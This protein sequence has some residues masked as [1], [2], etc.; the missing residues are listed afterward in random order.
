MQIL[1]VIG[2]ATDEFIF[3][4]SW[5]CGKACPID[6]LPE[7]DVL[8]DYLIFVPVPKYPRSTEIFKENTTN[9]DDKNKVKMMG[10]DKVWW[11]FIPGDKQQKELPSTCKLLLDNLDHDHFWY[12]TRKASQ[13]NHKN[14]RRHPKLPSHI[15]GPLTTAD[16]FTV[17][18]KERK[19]DYQLMVPHSFDYPGMT[20]Y[21]SIFEDVLGIPHPGPTGAANVVLQNKVLTR[22]ILKDI[23]GLN[24]PKGEVLKKTSGIRAFPH[25]SL[26]LPYVVK[27]AKEDNSNGVSL[28]REEAEVLPALEKA[29]YYGEEVIVEE[30]IPGREIRAGG[31]EDSTGNC[32]ALSCK[33]EYALRKDHPIRVREDKLTTKALPQKERKNSDEGKKNGKTS[34]TVLQATSDREFLTSNATDQEGSFLAPEIARKIDLAV[35]LAHEALGIRDYS[36]FDFRIHEVT[37]EAY[38]L[39]SCTFWTFSPISMLSLII[40]RSTER[41]LTS[42]FSSF[43]PECWRRASEEVWKRAMNRRALAK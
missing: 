43:D 10:N 16:M 36:L 1:Q 14:A 3:K 30:F 20:V 34:F 23:P 19:M 40:N 18:Q 4:V 33:I 5:L 13:L 8:Y 24:I 6:V 9:L 22:S 38:I 31:F 27:P 37:G 28:C 29:F 12:S 39:E 21:R 25:T 11:F 32:K 35:C 15:L 17:V 26:P 42:E 7:K 41:F 2:S